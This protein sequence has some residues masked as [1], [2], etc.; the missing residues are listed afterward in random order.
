VLLVRPID[1]AETMPGG[2][3]LLIADHRQKLTAD[4]F[5]VI[6]V[7]AFAECDPQRSRT[8]RK[9]ERP[10]EWESIDAPCPNCGKDE[11]WKCSAPPIC[12]PCGH[13][14]TTEEF[15]AFSRRVHAHPVRA[16]DWILCAPRS[17]IAGPDPEGSARFVHQDSVWAIFNEEPK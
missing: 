3:V 7:G 17:T 8:E 12:I 13:H 2:K 11:A 10:H 5:E 1:V 16:G 15:K 14:V 6:A 4:Q 9:C